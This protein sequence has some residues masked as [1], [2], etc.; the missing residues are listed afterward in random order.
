MYWKLDA[1]SVVCSVQ[2]AVCIIQCAVCSVHCIVE[3]VVCRV[4]LVVFSVMHYAVYRAVCSV[5]YSV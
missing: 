2:C 1:V 3:R 5:L 4:Q